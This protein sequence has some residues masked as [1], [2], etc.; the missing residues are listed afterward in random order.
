MRSGSLNGIIGMVVAV[1]DSK[2]VDKFNCE[3]IDE[4]KAT[5]GIRVIDTEGPPALL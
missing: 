5:E 2:R 1:F 3:G 4:D